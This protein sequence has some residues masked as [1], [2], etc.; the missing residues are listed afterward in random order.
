M[1]VLQYV[2][3]ARATRMKSRH[4]ALWVA[5]VCASDERVSVGRAPL[6]PKDLGFTG[7]ETS[8]AYFRRLLAPEAGQ[9]VERRQDWLVPDLSFWALGGPGLR[10]AA[11]AKDFGPE[12]NAWQVVCIGEDADAGAPFLNSRNVDFGDTLTPT[13]QVRFVRSGPLRLRRVV[14]LTRGGGTYDASF[15][16]FTPAMLFRDVYAD[17]DP[18]A[19]AT[20][21][22]VMQP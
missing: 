2:D 13:S 9:V 11:A 7:S 15:R 5:L 1:W 4:R 18:A 12:N 14:W 19:T 20:V 17:S 3:L 21:Y 22:R 6:W 10:E 8:T 16:V